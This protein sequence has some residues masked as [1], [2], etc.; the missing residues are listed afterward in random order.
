[1]ANKSKQKGS[2]FERLI[3]LMTQDVGVPCKRA[4]G[5]NGAA[6]GMHEEVDVVIDKNFKVQAK[7]R[8]AMGQWMIPNNNVNAQLIK[9]DRE[10]M[11]FESMCTTRLVNIIHEDIQ[12][13]LQYIYDDYK[14]MC[15]IPVDFNLEGKRIRGH[16]DVAIEIDEDNVMLIDIKTLGA[17]P[18]QKVYGIL[19]NRAKKPQWMYKYQLATYAIGLKRNYQYKNVYMY[20][21]NYKKDNS[22]MRFVEVDTDLYEKEAKY[23]W[24][25]THSLVTQLHKDPERIKEL[26]DGPVENW[27][28]NYCDYTRYCPVKYVKEK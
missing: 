19:K 5:S 27:E 2:R 14:V 1:M 12:N 18:W 3:V 10:D 23:Y 20:L 26:I 11:S 22:D 13:A 8:K 17:Y 4:W 9:A 21:L 28:C 6:L 24:R 7:C 25:Q 15:E 16:L